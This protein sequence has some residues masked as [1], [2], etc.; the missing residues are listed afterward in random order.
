MT[1]WLNAAGHYA[2][3]AVVGGLVAR[4]IATHP[5][6]KLTRQLERMTEKLDRLDPK[7]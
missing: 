3:A 4:T 1:G 6:R 2:L 7:E 5:L